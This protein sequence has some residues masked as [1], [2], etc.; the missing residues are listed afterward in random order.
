MTSK[1]VL[2]ADTFLFHDGDKGLL[3]N[4]K[5]SSFCLFDAR[6][7]SIR[8][9]I[10]QWED[11]GNLYTAKI[12]YSNNDTAFLL[13]LSE[14]ED[15][16]LGMVVSGT[17]EAPLSFP[18]V[19]RIKRSIDNLPAWYEGT[20]G[21]LPVSHYLKRLIV[22]LGGETEHRGTWGTAI[23]PESS[24]AK[25]NVDSFLSFI[26]RID[27]KALKSMTLIISE[28]DDAQIMACANNLTEFKDIVR[29]SFF[30]PDPSF[31]ND[32][33]DKLVAEGYVITQECPSDTSIEK[34]SWEPGRCYQLL[35]R[36]E[37]EVEHWETLLQGSENVNYDFK[38]V[39]D[40]NLDF[41]RK[42]IFLSEEEILSQKLTK[43][44]IFRHQALNVNQFGTLFVFPDGTLHPAKD[45]PTIGTLG[46]SIHQIV[47][48]ELEQNHAWRQTRR[49]MEPCKDCLYH[50]L[51]PS[52]SMYERIF[53][54]P[55]CSYWQK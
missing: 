10:E 54:V 27:K 48:R 41:F 6:N 23:T 1:I 51:C 2:M 13:F 12:E 35:V 3:Y 4:C 40:D 46:E 32:T 24:S 36:S 38:P 30:D 39:A 25:L 31:K 55:G 50:D 5:E 20:T 9:A 29:F 45:A 44:D 52:P 34:V 17:E 26:S 33:L 21:S 22:H 53:G 8:S 47:I 49:L 7:K 14:I 15:K 43:K 18:P 42:N 37:E 28:W 19:L 11:I 16:K